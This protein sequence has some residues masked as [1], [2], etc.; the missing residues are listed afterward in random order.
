[1]RRRAKRW[2]Q[3]TNCD[4]RSWLRRFMAS[5]FLRREEMDW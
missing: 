1:M 3:E 2:K 5:P 4:R